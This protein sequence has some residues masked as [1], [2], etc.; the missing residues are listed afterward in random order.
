MNAQT[1]TREDR[2]SSDPALIAERLS[3]MA[4]RVL[5]QKADALRFGGER[6][7]GSDGTAEKAA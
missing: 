1:P 4:R 3:P 5:A 2:R 7:T 6:P